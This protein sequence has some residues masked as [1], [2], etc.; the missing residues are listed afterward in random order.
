RGQALGILGGAT[1]LHAIGLI[2]DRRH[3]GPWL[4]LLVQVLVAAA[5]VVF[6]GVRV[7]HHWGPTASI[8]LSILWIVAITNSFNFLDNM[9][10][11]AAGV[12]C[13]AGLAL[14]GAAAGMGQIF[15]PAWLCVLVGS[16][17]GFLL[18]NFP[19]ASIF[20]GDA[21]SLVVGYM[22]AVLSCLTTYT[23]GRQ[24]A[25]EL[26]YGVL[27]PVLMMAVPLYDTASVMLI[28]IAERRNP[29]IGDTRHFSHR[30]QKRGMSKRKTVLTIY[31][32]TAS[33]AIAAS[34]LPHV[35]SVAAAVMMVAQVVF[36]L[37]IIAVLES[38][39]R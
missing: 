22:L 33:T 14:L 21:G 7:A 5:V 20:M 15:V 18:H 12:A 38:T 16:L 29:M 25:V 37:L 8:T 11:L 35:A 6:V 30:L 24:N 27:A 39:D 31:L 36:I 9:D 32:C 2:D 28:R 17:L 13:I 19:P 34:L 3:L 10:G 26:L 1:V 4:K 23:T